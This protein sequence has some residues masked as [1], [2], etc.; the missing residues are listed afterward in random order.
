MLLLQ[1]EIMASELRPPAT[2]CRQSTLLVEDL[3]RGCNGVVSAT[4]VVNTRASA[5]F[6]CRPISRTRQTAGEH[7]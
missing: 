3:E 7:Q 1:Q 5:P 6:R 2:V 4:S